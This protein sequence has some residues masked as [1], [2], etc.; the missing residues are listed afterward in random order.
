MRNVFTSGKICYIMATW[1]TDRKDMS[2]YGISFFVNWKSEEKQEYERWQTDESSSAGY[3]FRQPDENYFEFY[4]TDLSRECFS[5]V[6]QH[7]RRGDRR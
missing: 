5:A 4:I 3:D 2:G 7:G 1:K 6:L